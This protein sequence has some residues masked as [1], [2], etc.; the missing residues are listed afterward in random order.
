MCLKLDTSG[1]PSSK[2][3]HKHPL[4]TCWVP[5]LLGAE[6]PD[7]DDCFITDESLDPSEQ[8]IVTRS[9]ALRLH[10]EAHHETSG[11]HLEVFSTEPA[12]QL[13]DGK[14]I[15]VP[16]TEVTGDQVEGFGARA[17]FCIEPMRYTNAVNVDEWNGMVTL[18]K[19]D[20]YGSRIVYRAW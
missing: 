6:G 18:K 9:Y 14:H 4:F 13:Y 20:K 3:P 7:F 10:L 8:K 11:K 16:A 2:K 5:L 19:G 15:D 12:F 17:G 1:I